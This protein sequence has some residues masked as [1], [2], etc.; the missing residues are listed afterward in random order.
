MD[1]IRL[2]AAGLELARERGW[3]SCAERHVD[4]YAAVAA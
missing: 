4:V 2:T 3:R 1:T